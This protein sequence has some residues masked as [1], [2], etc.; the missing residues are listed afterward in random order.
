[1]QVIRKVGEG[2]VKDELEYADY[3]LLVGE[4]L[5][6][7]RKKNKFPVAKITDSLKI[8]RSTYNNWEAGI[9]S[10]KGDQLINLASLFNTTV[11]YIVGRTDD[12][13]PINI[14]DMWDLIKDTK[15]VYKGKEITDD[16]ASAILSIIETYLKVNENKE[17]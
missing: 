16:Q 8:A 9:R 13:S 12:D 4:R 15:L 10:P 11:D 17:K 6:T 5:K 7:L 2:M 1:V 3:Q 14:E